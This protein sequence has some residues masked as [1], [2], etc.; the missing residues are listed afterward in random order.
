MLNINFIISD[1]SI[2]WLNLNLIETIF[3]SIEKD[4]KKD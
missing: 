1:S 4:I 3:K 2:W